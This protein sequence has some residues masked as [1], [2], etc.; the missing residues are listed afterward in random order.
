MTDGA[1]VG[2][3]PIPDIYHNL[4]CCEEPYWAITDLMTVYVMA[5]D[6]FYHLITQ[7]SNTLVS[8]NGFGGVS[9][10]SLCTTISLVSIS[11]PTL[12]YPR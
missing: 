4:S 3:F 11:P 6:V 1:A 10:S 2:L 12:G 7:F 9:K 8:Q 5:I